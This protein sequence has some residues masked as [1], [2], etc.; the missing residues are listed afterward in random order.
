MVRARPELRSC[1]LN[2][3]SAPA[4]ETGVHVTPCW[5]W[6]RTRMSGSSVNVIITGLKAAPVPIWALLLWPSLLQD[7]SSLPSS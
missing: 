5:L 2:A 1:A 7:A 4:C 3:L 6:Q